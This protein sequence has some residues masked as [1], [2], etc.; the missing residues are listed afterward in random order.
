MLLCI[1]HTGGAHIP[2]YYILQYEPGW[3]IAVSRRFNIFYTFIMKLRANPVI[4]FKANRIIAA[5]NK[6]AS[7]VCMHFSRS[8][9]GRNSIRTGEIDFRVVGRRQRHCSSCLPSHL[10]KLTDGQTNTST[11]WFLILFIDKIHWTERKILQITFL[12]SII[13]ATNCLLNQRSQA[14]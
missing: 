2:V 6:F 11:E 8:W 14:S 3:C 7:I 1:E 12:N 9:C 5:P 13:N 10:L 4:K